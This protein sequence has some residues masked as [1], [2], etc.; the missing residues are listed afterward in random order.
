MRSSGY[1]NEP[2]EL[3]AIIANEVHMAA[4]TKKFDARRAWEQLMGEAV[5]AAHEYAKKVVEGTHTTNDRAH[6]E[7]LYQIAR[8][9][10]EKFDAEYPTPEEPS[11]EKF[12]KRKWYDVFKF[13][14]G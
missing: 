2:Q 1:Y 11:A 12:L 4:L 9:A 13:W 14:H 7:S 10:R 8:T 6:V 5:Y 3:D